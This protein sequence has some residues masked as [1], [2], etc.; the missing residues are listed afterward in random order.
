[1]P[2]QNG[3]SIPMVKQWRPA[4]IAAPD[5]LTVSHL[6]VFLPLA[7]PATIDKCLPCK[8]TEMMEYC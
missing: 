8:T 5:S 2:V 1:V 6:L 7:S 4:P 3:T